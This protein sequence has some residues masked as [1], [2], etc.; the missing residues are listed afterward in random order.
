MSSEEQVELV[1]PTS[2]GTILVVEDDE[3]CR[4]RVCRI[5]EAD[6]FEVAPLESAN[7]AIRYM[8]GQNWSWSPWLVITDL[9]MDGMGGYQFIR[10]LSQIYPNKV[11]QSIVISRLQTADDISEAELAGAAAFI[12]KPIE[13]DS[14]IQTVYRVMAKD[15]KS[16]AFHHVA[17]AA[18]KSK[19][20]AKRRA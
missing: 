17:N 1:R 10:R 12:A 9:V 14:L 4:E 13:E 16:R 19:R 7:H 3:E 5:L 20:L 8:E 18:T 15:G 6:D 2:S 11:I